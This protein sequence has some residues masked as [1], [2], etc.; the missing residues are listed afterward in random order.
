MKK[1]LTDLEI[2]RHNKIKEMLSKG[3]NPYPSFNK[4]ITHL[5]VEL[6]K[7]FDSKSRDQLI[8]EENVVSIAGRVMLM[9]GPFIVIMDSAGKTQ[10]YIDKNNKTLM[11]A[12]NFVDIGDIVWT[13]G[14]LMKTNTGELTIRMNKIFILSKSLKPLPEKYHGLVNVEDRYRK[15]YLDLIMNSNARDTLLQRTKIMRWIRTFFDDLGYVEVDTPVL[16]SY[17]GG[18]S[19]KPF[20][21]HHNSLNSDFYLRIATEIPLKKLIVGGIGRVYEI[22]RLFRNEGI[23][24]THNPEFTSIEFYESY[25]NLE[26]MMNRVEEVFR[27]IAKNLNLEKMEYKDQ[28][29]DFSKKFARVNM[30]D[31]IYNETK[32][33]FRK[34]TTLN[35][36]KKLAKE[37]NINIEDFFEVGHIINCFFEEYVEDKLQQPTFIYN[38]PIEISPLAATNID[39]LKFT[40]RAELFICGKEYANLYTELNDPIEQLR[41]FKLQLNEKKLGNDEANEIDHDFIDALEYGMPPTGGAGIGI[42][43]M[44]MLFTNHTSIREVIT[45]PHLKNKK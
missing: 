24:T 34:V 25:S 15:K 20:V 41:R 8:A 22:G 26:G 14:R 23:D 28:K 6:K 4:K 9:R 29:I 37:S 35:E 5:S 3:I 30:I 44:I 43:R 40:D 19:A 18:A 2:I 36:A 45:F 17:L 10:G 32:I 38:Y 12:I 11:E 21:T 1:K 33:D 39:D 27:F 42:D 7:N 16:H 31:A 13:N